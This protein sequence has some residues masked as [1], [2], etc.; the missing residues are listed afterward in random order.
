MTVPQDIQSPKEPAVVAGPSLI[1][2]MLE[3]IDIR[4]Q[5][6]AYS[7][8]RRGL[9]EII[10]A[11]LVPERKD[12]K[13]NQAMVVDM[14]AEMD[15]KLS[16][17][18]DAILHHA[19]FQKFES[20]WRGLKLSVDRTN[21]RENIQ[22]EIL[23]V[24]KE[25]LLTDFV[26]APDVTKSALYKH[27]YTAEFG[28]FGGNPIGA[29]IANYDFGPGPQDVKL[30][31][32]VA[33]VATMA[34]AP[35]IAAAGP[36]FFGMESYLRIPNLRDLKTHFEGPQYIKW[37]SFRESEDSRSVALCMPRFL[38]RLPYGQETEPAK[39]FNYNESLSNGHESYLWGNTAF[40]FATRLTESFA[41]SRWYTNI[42]GPISGGTVD[43]LP[44]HVF[45]AM[46]GIET[47]IPTEILISGEREKE[48]ADAGFIALTMRKGSDNA[49]FFSANSVQRPKT[50]GQ[51]AAGK[52][53]EANYRLGTQLPYLFIINRLAHYIKVLQTEQ[54]GG[55]KD[56]ADLERELNTWISQYVSAM[57]AVTD[58][59]RRRRPLR[60]AQVTVSD[61][62][63]N[64]G[65]Y[66]V[67]LKVVPHIKYMGAFFTLSLVGKLNK[68]R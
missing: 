42:I 36:K 68:L 14:I 65:W 31:Q 29:M 10:K 38:L 60:D 51:S 40:A 15:K 26:E 59:V 18:V 48:L 37:N 62:E 20:A 12:M 63:G 44:V 57:D 30:L 64:P 58:E 17:Q 52:V 19:T 6:E 54:L 11:L 34:H 7:P 41:K 50:F 66:R 23:N 45:E 1:D 32:Y 22:F 39:M 67:D 55:T 9:E 61:V 16:A 3:S 2:Q 33:S 25:E 5:E 35:F 53:A 21:F 4:P 43:N 27:L 13:V 8:A 49:C 28:M 47:K 56:R 24:S 46:G